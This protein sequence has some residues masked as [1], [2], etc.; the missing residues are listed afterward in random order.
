MFTS[1]SNKPKKEVE[2]NTIF[3][4]IMANEF[5]KT[6]EKM[7]NNK[8]RNDELLLILLTDIC[9]LENNLRDEEKTVE[10]NTDLLTD[11]FNSLLVNDMP[12]VEEVLKKYLKSIR[13][14]DYFTVVMNHIKLCVLDG[15]LTQLRG[16]PCGFS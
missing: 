5:D 14:E 11:L 15:D 16:S 12:L 2:G 7:S 1:R 8:G 6:F 13:H 4:Y 10:K 9:K 3:S